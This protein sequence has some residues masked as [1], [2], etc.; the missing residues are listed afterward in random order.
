[1]KE[2]ACFQVR[3]TGVLI[4]EERILLVKQRVTEDRRWSLPGGRVEEGETLEKAIVR[5]MKE[6]TGLHTEIVKLLYGCDKPEAQ[7][8][9]IHITFLLR[10]LGGRLTLPSN[11]FDDNP[12]SDV[13]MVPIADLPNYQFSEKFMNLTLDYF[14]GSGNYMGLKSS[15]GL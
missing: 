10:K 8:A 11:E 3:V 7:S 1:M 15:I 6:E 9:L 14:P 13:R 12:I 2:M 5:E 4:E